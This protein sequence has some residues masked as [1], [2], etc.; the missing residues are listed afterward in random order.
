V[1]EPPEPQS[2]LLLLERLS[3]LDVPT[4][5]AQEAESMAP[6][7]AARVAAAASEL[8]AGYTTRA[9]RGEE[10]FRTLVLRALKQ[11]RYDARNLGHSGLASSAY[12]HFTSPI[13]RYPDLVVHRALLD[14]LGAGAD[15]VPGDLEERAEHCSVREREAAEVEYLA[16]EI[17]LAWLLES[18]LFELGWEHVFEGEVIGVIPGGLFARFG[19]VF[20]AFL[21]ARRLADDYY[22]LDELATALVGRRGGRRFR[23][24]DPIDVQVADIRRAE[25]KV[26][27]TVPGGRNRQRGKVG[28]RR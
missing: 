10:A 28:R 14:E 17:C 12:A 22:E 18:R 1:H 8:V 25:G 20:E 16:D 4:P 7:E 15:G 6:R 23:L 13:R 11:A 9:R 24:G 19:E 5:P 26:E 21:P 2:V 27:V 3:E